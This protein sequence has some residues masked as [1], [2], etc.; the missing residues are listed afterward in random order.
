MHYYA[1]SLNTCCWQVGTSFHHASLLSIHKHPVYRLKVQDFSRSF[2]NSLTF[3]SDPLF[4][5]NYLDKDSG[6]EAPEHT[7]ANFTHLSIACFGFDVCVSDLKSGRVSN[8]ASQLSCLS[9]SG[10]D[11]PLTRLQF[12]QL[13]CLSSSVGTAFS[14]RQS[15]LSCSV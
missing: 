7:S 12:H 11:T 14:R 4:T 2:T 5:G 1:L 9:N 3:S 8:L 15:A 13:S 10:G 6:Q